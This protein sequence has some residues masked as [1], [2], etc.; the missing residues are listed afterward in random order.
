NRDR[1]RRAVLPLREAPGMALHNSQLRCVRSEH[2][3]LNDGGVS[4]KIRRGDCDEFARPRYRVLGH[5]NAEVERTCATRIYNRA[6]YGD[7][8]RVHADVVGGTDSKGN[9]RARDDRRWWRA[10]KGYKG[11][12]LVDAKR[13]SGA[14]GV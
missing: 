12:T 7:R 1:I 2:G 11:R 4:G 10:R 5:R 8:Y 14:C 6:V 9:R 13:D 3:L